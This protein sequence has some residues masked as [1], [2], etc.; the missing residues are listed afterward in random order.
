MLNAKKLTVNIVHQFKIN[1]MYLDDHK[2]LKSIINSQQKDLTGVKCPVAFN[3]QINSPEQLHQGRC[4]KSN[5]CQIS[6]V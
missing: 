2:F 4:E 1:T 5:H 3:T 6:S